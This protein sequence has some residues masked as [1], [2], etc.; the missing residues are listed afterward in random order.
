MG[1]NWSD[2][3]AAEACAHH[4]RAA[5]E[6]SAPLSTNWPRVASDIVAKYTVDKDLGEYADKLPV[7]DLSDQDR[8]RLIVHARRDAAQALYQVGVL[9]DELDGR[10]KRKEFRRKMLGYG[11][12]SIFLAISIWLW[13]GAFGLR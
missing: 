2:Q 9:V 8:D 3:T 4:L 13:S 12:I 7:Y 1:A 11:F 6:L 10:R 5:R